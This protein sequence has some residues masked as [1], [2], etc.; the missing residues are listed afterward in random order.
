MW[1]FLHIEIEDMVAAISPDTEQSGSGFD[2][3]SYG[4][5]VG[6]TTGTSDTVANRASISKVSTTLWR[7]FA[8]VFMPYNSS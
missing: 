5:T 2:L 4:N 3:Y 8:L 1:Y 6:A 7:S